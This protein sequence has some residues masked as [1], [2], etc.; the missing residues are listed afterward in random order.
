MLTDCAVLRSA[1]PI[2]SA[3]AMN[4]LLNTSSSIG[5]A[6]FAEPLALAR[7]GAR[8]NEVVVVAHVKRP[9]RLDDDRLM[10]LDDERGP[11]DRRA[12]PDRLALH[13]GRVVPVPARIEFGRGVRR[14]VVLHLSQRER[15]EAHGNAASG[16]GG[17]RLRRGNPSPARSPDSRSDLSPWERCVGVMPPSLARRPPPRSPRR[18]SPSPARRSRS[19]GD[20][21]PRSRGA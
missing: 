11:A 12:R 20:A 18:R 8:Q 7:L 1:S 10:R 16:R 13:D 9:A 17:E 3:I 21:A 6:S 5:S 15:S 4:R 19:A 2:C 14:R